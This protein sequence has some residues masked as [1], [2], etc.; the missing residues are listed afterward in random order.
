MGQIFKIREVERDDE[1]GVIKKEI[2]DYNGN[3]SFES[4]IVSQKNVTQYTSVQSVKVNEITRQI[5][6]NTIN[7]LETKGIK[8]FATTVKSEFL[9]GKLNATIFNLRFDAVPN[10]DDLRLL[11]HALHSSSEN[12]MILPTVK[13]GLLQEN[14]KYSEK[15]IQDY[16]RMMRLIINETE[17][18][19]N[20]KEFIGTIPLIPPK[21]V[22]RII[23]FYLSEDLRAFVI[24]VNTKDII[25]HEGDFRVILSEINKKK[26]LTETLIFA[27]NLGFKQFEMHELRSDDFLS[28]FAYVD[29][30][31]GNFKTRGGRGM[32]G[33]PRA[34]VFS[35]DRYSYLVTTYSE[36]SK[37][38][39]QKVTYSSLKNYNR[40]EQLN[41]SLKVRNLLGIEKMKKYL[42]TKAAVDTT[43]M[44]R[45]ESIASKV[46]IA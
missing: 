10:D 4:P 3:F 22:R 40:A 31:G 43:S 9:V 14:Q 2:S 29:V 46:R 7:E 1:L 44:K 21:F 39:G 16:I 12:T 13:F 8:P 45:L 32:S 42:Q 20:R 23:E 27:C 35:R 28:L 15:R 41:E 37:M 33:I 11:S 26:P 17:A 36:A 18:I 19:G 5:D 34:K 30:L 6:N 38:L 24:D 25:L